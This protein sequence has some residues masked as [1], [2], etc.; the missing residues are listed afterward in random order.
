MTFS[1]KIKDEINAIVPKSRHCTIADLCGYIAFKGELPDLIALSKEADKKYYT[2]IKKVL[3]FSDKLTDDAL[4]R[5]ILTTTEIASL[6]NTLRLDVTLDSVDAMVLQ[7][8]CCKRAFIRGAFAAAGSVSDPNKGYH[9]EVYVASEDLADTLMSCMEFFEL[10]PKVTTRKGSF[11]V[12]IKEG[13]EI[14]EALRV[15]EASKSVMEF[16]NVRII[17]EMR[18]QVNRKVNCETANITKVVGAAVKQIEAINILKQAGQL[19]S[20]TPQLQEMATLRVAN[21]E[22]SLDELGKLLDPPLKKSG[23]NHR[24][25]KLMALAEEYKK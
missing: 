9:F 5:H 4:H 16:E 23:V 15:M 7:Q 3:G 22:M 10:K 21:P 25:T 19:K 2:L 12:Y 8:P 24:L 6:L 18:G 11:V 13:E 20:L 14:C 1:S 17:R